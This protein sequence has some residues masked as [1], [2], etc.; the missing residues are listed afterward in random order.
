M[1]FIAEFGGHKKEETMLLFCMINNILFLCSANELTLHN[2]ITHLTIHC[3]YIWLCWPLFCVSAIFVLLFAIVTAV[4]MV[5]ASAKM[6][7]TMLRNILRS[8]M[9]F[10][11]TT[12][13][14]RILNRF[15]RDIETID[16]ILPQLIRSFLNT[17]FAVIAT[18]VV[19][20]YSTPIFLS[21]VVPLGILYYF[22][23]VKYTAL[24]YSKTIFFIPGYAQLLPLHTLVLSS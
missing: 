24:Y 1:A 17:F 3:T 5:R 18:I 21:V 10:F 4:S 6:H 22:V 8:P 19:I 7:L 11:D 2:M 20:S 12:P 23:Q 15:S 13:I 14:G 16:T 9:S